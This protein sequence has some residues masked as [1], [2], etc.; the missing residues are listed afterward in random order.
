MDSTHTPATWKHN[1]SSLLNL[2]MDER[3]NKLKHLGIYRHSH[4]H[5]HS[6]S[7]QLLYSYRPKQTS[8]ISSHRKSRASHRGK[9]LTSSMH[10]RNTQRESHLIPQ[11]VKSFTQGESVDFKHAQEGGER[12]RERERE[13]SYA[14]QI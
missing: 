3:E 4:S 7:I 12:E 11:K 9:V 10:R 5:S 1:L 13:S 2:A 14:M 6:P 8:I